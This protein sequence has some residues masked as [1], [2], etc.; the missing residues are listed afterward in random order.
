M[1]EFNITEDTLK[2]LNPSLVSVENK[3]FFE[4]MMLRPKKVRR[5]LMEAKID[6]YSE[7]RTPILPQYKTFI[8]E[9]LTV[10][11]LQVEDATYEYDALHAFGICTHY[12]TIMKGYPLED[13]IDLIFNALAK[14]LK[15]DPVRLRD[16][17]KRILTY[18]QQTPLSGEELLNAEEGE[19]APIFNNVRSNRYFKYC[20]TWGVGLARVME[21]KGVEPNMDAFN[22]WGRNLKNVY[23]SRF[24][25]SWVEFSSDQV[26]MQ[27]VEAMQKQI[28]IRE[29]RRAADRLEEKAAMA[30]QEKKRILNLNIALLEK[31]RREEKKGLENMREYVRSEQE[32]EL[33]EQQI[34][35]LEKQGD[36]TFFKF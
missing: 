20:D 24:L 16:D 27:G 29:K 15:F 13:E 28:L 36:Q 33:L 35:E 8:T 6:F 4:K 2:S 14:A 7:Y 10:L 30:E 18:V 31:K 19:L 3:E 26:K 11:L 22:I 32:R 5:T 12:Y 25:D 21:L 17:A 1:K 9:F 34:K 23:A